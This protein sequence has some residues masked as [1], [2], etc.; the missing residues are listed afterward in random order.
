MTI[1]RRGFFGALTALPFALGQPTQARPTVVKTMVNRFPVAGFQYYQG[2]SVINHLCRGDALTLR[3]EPTNP[4]D[5][6][7]VEIYADRVKLGYVPRTDN[8]HLSR[9]LR[10]GLTLVCEVDEATPDGSSWD[11]LRVK[12]FML[13]EERN[14]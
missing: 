7:A 8:K 3:A 11:A 9:M 2:E 14:A 5:Y 13:T 1:S 12:V 4:Y 10:D 6:Y